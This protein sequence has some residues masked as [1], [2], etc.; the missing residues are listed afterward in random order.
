MWTLWSC[1][2]ISWGSLGAQSLSS[3]WLGKWEGTVEI[4]SNNQKQ[5][6]FSMSL[7]ISPA[8][9]AW[10]FIITYQMNPEKPD[11]R[12]YSLLVLEDSSGHFVID[13]HNSI[14]LD[15]YLNANCLYSGFGG[16]G[17]ELMSRMCLEG[18]ELAYEIMSVKSEPIR[19]SGGTLMKG[20]SIP[21]IRSYELYHLMRARLTKGSG[22][23]ED[24]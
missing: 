8:D 13:E 14:L 3:D 11:V 4:W 22:Q 1:L 23:A 2:F 17:S 21:S 20:D 19:E 9:T 7:E 10:N 5:N 15:T 24:K 6:A 12:N 16:M 18:K